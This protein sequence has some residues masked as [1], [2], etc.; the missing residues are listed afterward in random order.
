MECFDETWENHYLC[1]KAIVGAWKKLSDSWIWDMSV[2]Y[3]HCK[4]NVVADVLSWLSM[5]NISHVEYDEKEQFQYV[6]R[7]VW[8]G[9]RVVG[10]HEGVVIVQNAYESFFLLYV[11][12]KNL[13]LTLVDLKN[14]MSKKI[15]WGFLQRGEG[16]ISYQSRLCV[17]NVDGLRN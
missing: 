16:V 12:A 14:N 11:N 15:H 17:L 9:V 4:E 10:S 3:H 7:L 2:V 1:F 8:L 5:K 6:H 13:N